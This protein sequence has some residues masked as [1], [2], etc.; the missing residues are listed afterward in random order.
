LEDHQERADPQGRRVPADTEAA[1]SA[2]LPPKTVAEACMVARA[3]E[4]LAVAADR[5]DSRVPLAP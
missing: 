4:V 3:P 2:A 1:Y 5:R